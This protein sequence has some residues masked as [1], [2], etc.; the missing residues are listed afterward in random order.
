MVSSSNLANAI[1]M[2]TATHQKSAQS[3]TNS[4]KDAI[5]LFAK[6]DR[7]VLEAALAA[8]WPGQAYRL[9]KPAETGLLMLR[10][11]IGGDGAAFNLGEATVSKAI[12]E[13]PDGTRGYGQCLG[14]D[15]KKAEC[16]AVLDALWQTDAEKVERL[17][18]N[19]VRQALDEKRAKAA[20]QTAATK[21]DFFTLVR[22]ED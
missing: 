8:H 10:G 2:S 6:A 4:R 1:F 3:S 17:V 13:L 19:P 20:A 21:V 14:R 22:G 9:L 7:H 15:A 12:V 16:A 18:L 11:R 5:A